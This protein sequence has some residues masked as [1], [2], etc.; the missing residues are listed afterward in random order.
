MPH[1]F[2]V[3]DSVYVRRHRAQN[4]E[5]RWKGPYV[6]LLTTPTAVKV[7]GITSWI[8]A[9]HLKPASPPGM[10]WKL[11]KTDNPL[12]IKIRRVGNGTVDPSSDMRLSP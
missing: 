6:V 4:L 2:Q 9:S 11:E 7:D 10:E 1:R 5:P 8:H 12:K 3:G